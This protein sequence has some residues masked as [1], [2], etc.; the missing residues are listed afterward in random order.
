[1]TPA[2]A[3]AMADET[4]AYWRARGIRCV[5]VAAE[6]RCHRSWPAVRY[7]MTRWLLDVGAD[8]RTAA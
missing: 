8:L 1:M 7:C 4:I 5:D 3:R 6:L 2:E